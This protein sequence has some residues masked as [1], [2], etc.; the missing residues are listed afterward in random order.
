MK[1]II[2]TI[3][4]VLMLFVLIAPMTAHASSYSDVYDYANLL[5]TTEEQ[6]LSELATDYKNEYGVNVV[7]L[8]Y[9]NANGKS[10]MRYTDDFYDEIHY[11]ESGILFAIDMDNREMYINTVGTCIN[12]LSDSERNTIFNETQNYV[13]NK[14]YYKFF[15]KTCKK[16]FGKMYDEGLAAENDKVQWWIPTGTS[17]IITLIVMAIVTIILIAIHNKANKKISASTY[18]ANDGYKV[19]DRKETFLRT[20]ETVS[21]G[22][23]KSSGSGGSSSHRSSGGVRHGGGGRKF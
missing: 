2:S 6:K 17:I 15:D 8:T 4:I 21:R 9:D 18:I 16:A 11:N 3:L 22:Y 23:Y 19:Y 10:T 5:S 7:F 12:A 1:K 14:Q 13:K 20:Y